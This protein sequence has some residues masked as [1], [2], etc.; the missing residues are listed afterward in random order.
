MTKKIESVEELRTDI[1]GNILRVGDTVACDTVGRQD[2]AVGVIDSF[3]TK[4]VNVVSPTNA[5]RPYARRYNKYSTQCVLIKRGDSVEPVA[6][7][8]FT[9][10]QVQ[11]MIDDT[12]NS[13]AAIVDRQLGTGTALVH[14]IRALASPGSYVNP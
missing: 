10:D 1:H 5:N 11:K 12:V 3:G 7:E 9:K 4:M 6:G 8:T 2:L 14:E 13:C